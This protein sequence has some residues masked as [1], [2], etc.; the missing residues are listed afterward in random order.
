MNTYH[1]THD[2]PTPVLL[3]DWPVAQ[4]NIEIAADSVKGKTARLRP[5]FKN[6]K[7]TALA[8]HQLQGGNC[9]GMTVSNLVEAAALVD[10]GVDNVLIA[11]Q[12]AGAAN[13]ARL[14]DLAGRAQVRVAVDSMANSQPISEAA[15]AA[16]MKVGVLLEVDTG[17][18]RCGVQPGPDAVELAKRIASLPGL[19]FDGIQAYE[20]H[21]I[22]I[23][24]HDERAE[25]TRQAMQLAIDTRHLM[26]AGGLKVNILSGAG[27][28]TYHVAAEM[29]GVDELQI[30]TYVTMDWMYKKRV[31]Y[32][33]DIALT[34]GTTVIS[35]QDDRF[36][37]NIGVKGIG[38]E[39]GPP[40]V[41]GHPEFEIRSL[42]S[43]EHTT[44]HATG[45]NVRV[46][47]ML[48]LIPSHSCTTCSRHSQLVVHEDGNVCDIW[49]IDAGGY[50][51][52]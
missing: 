24:D 17:M 12:V 52:D 20:G 10:A 33:F 3:L 44:V 13:I 30:G 7:C 1:T 26:E 29:P 40:I 21:A 49:P 47:D 31:I 39:F 9:I 8:K 50:P 48:E 35:V 32:G 18:T 37:L 14:I 51:I 16:D 28:A 6:H 27:T 46:G 42:L 45:H 43:E 38:S 34:I 4:R 19:Q 2:L 15:T 36:V 5:H 23:D 22:C 41:K 11:N 25:V